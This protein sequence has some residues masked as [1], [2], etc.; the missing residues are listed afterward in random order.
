MRPAPLASSN[1][2][3]PP[4]VGQ[5]RL[6]V[7]QMI[8][9]DGTAPGVLA[10]TAGPNVQQTAGLVIPSVPNDGTAADLTAPAMFSFL[11]GAYSAKYGV[12]GDEMRTVLTHIAQKNHANGAKNERSHFQSEVTAK[13]IE[14]S[15]KMAGMLGVFDCSGI[16]DGS[17]AAI[18]CRAE[19]V[20]RYTSKPMYVRALSL[21]VGNGTGAS[22]PG[23]DYTTFPEVVASAQVAYRQA[24][25]TESRHAAV[26][27][28]GSRLLHPDRARVDGGP[29]FLCA[30]P[31]VERRAV[32]SIRP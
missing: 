12:T 29:W 17:A 25:I 27:G 30:R 1:L 11:V 26:D 15:P 24:G 28:R 20:H 19:D 10:P 3:T 5:Q 22:D 13:A 31:R 9:F 21:A 4:I 7:V 8:R 23:Y 2:T 14:S 18:I 6:Q 32:R 16:S